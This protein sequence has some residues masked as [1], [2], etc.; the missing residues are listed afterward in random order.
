MAAVDETVPWL[1]DALALEQV[2]SCCRPPTRSPTG[3]LRVSR[4]AELAVERSRLPRADWAVPEPG[5]RGS[6]PQG[7]DGRPLEAKTSAGVLSGAWA[8]P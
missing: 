4:V 5:R 3:T 6:L 2:V 8:A 7:S 1:P